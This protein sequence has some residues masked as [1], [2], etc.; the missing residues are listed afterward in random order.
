MIIPRVENNGYEKA[1][2]P[3][4]ISCQLEILAQ[5][6]KALAAVPGGS[7]VNSAPHAMRGAGSHGKHCEEV[8]PSQYLYI[9]ARSRAGTELIAMSQVSCDRRGGD[10]YAVSPFFIELMTDEHFFTFLTR[11]HLTLV[12][13]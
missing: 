6:H 11:R 9:S 7:Q 13:I 2:P 3:I 4:S 1:I 8:I 5:K 12:P 10:A